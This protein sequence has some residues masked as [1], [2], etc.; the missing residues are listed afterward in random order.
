MYTLADGSLKRHIVLC[1]VGSPWHESLHV[2]ILVLSLST[3]GNPDPRD[4]PNLELRPDVSVIS[5]GMNPI[6][7]L[8]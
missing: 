8:R 5:T 4:F 1:Y 7:L 2:A 6:R 3:S